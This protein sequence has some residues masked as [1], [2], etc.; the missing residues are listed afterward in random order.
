[1]LAKLGAFIT[2]AA[3]SVGGTTF[4]RSL[5]GLIIRTKPLPTY[6]NGPLAAEAR[7]RTATLN[8]V[9]AGLSLA[10]IADW[11]T[12]AD[13]VPWF[14]RFGD[15]VA[16]TAYRA[17]MRC[18]LASLVTKAANFQFPIQS[19]APSD[20]AS[21]LPA[22]LQ[23]FLTSGPTAL[24]LQSIDA[25]VPTNTYLGV[26]ATKPKKPRPRGDRPTVQDSGLL[27]V[28]PPGTTFVIDIS[29]DYIAKF[30]RLP[31]PAAGEGCTVR[32]QPY[33]A[34]SYWPGISATLAMLT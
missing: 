22:S 25:T 34:T 29:S 6:R 33:S 16:G 5:S 20:I 18:N 9:W 7:Q 11:Q 17:F 13:S 32:V 30:G 12:L 27:T 2:H 21:S 3:G 8:N 4:Q 15:P 23:L 1:M 28:V 10:Q 19:L 26:F 14:N 24:E 31:N